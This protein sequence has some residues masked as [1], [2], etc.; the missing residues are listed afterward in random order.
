MILAC[1]ALTLFAKSCQGTAICCLGL[2]LVKPI[3][4]LPPKPDIHRRN[5][6]F[7]FRPGAD[8][9]S[10]INQQIMAR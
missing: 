3:S 2:R 9:H 10:S 1:A 6:D 8:E 4:A 5:L 7:R